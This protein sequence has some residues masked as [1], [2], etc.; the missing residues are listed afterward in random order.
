MLVKGKEEVKVLLLTGF[1]VRDSQEWTTL[2][3]EF[4]FI[5]KIEQMSDRVRVTEEGK[6]AEGKSIYMVQIGDPLLSDREIAEGRNIFYYGE[7][8]WG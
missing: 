3:E 8:T 5:K 1:E 6:S 2:E 7:P 4:E